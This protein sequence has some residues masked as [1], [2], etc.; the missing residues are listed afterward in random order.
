[1]LK[2]AIIYGLRGC[3]KGVLRNWTKAHR[4][5]GQDTQKMAVAGSITEGEVSFRLDHSG[6]VLE[7]RAMD[8]QTSMDRWNA[9]EG[10][11]ETEGHNA[12]QDGGDR[13]SAWTAEW[14]FRVLLAPRRVRTSY[15]EEE[16]L[17]NFARSQREGVR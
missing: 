14:V 17:R 5:E 6:M 9:V 2:C 8:Y 3:T 7:R 13:L 15:Q 1:V 16:A 4:K 11:L 10:M 12:P